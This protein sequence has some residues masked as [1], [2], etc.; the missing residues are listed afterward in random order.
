MFHTYKQGCS[1]A[2]ATS[3]SMALAERTM[4]TDLQL[5]QL[6]NQ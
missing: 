3:L 6:E 5:K 4:R 2:W 1:L